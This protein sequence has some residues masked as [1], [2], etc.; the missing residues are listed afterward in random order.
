MSD[1][2]ISYSRHDSGF[3]HHLFGALSAESKDTWVDWED[4]PPT[5]EW[6]EEIKAAIE[7]A[8]SVIFVLSPDSVNS[9]ICKAEINHAA[10][11]NKRLVPIVCREVE[12]EQVPNSLARLNWIFFRESD[13][14]E[15]SFST[16]LEAL[17]TDLEWLHDHT[18]LLVK[19]LEWSSQNQEKSLLLRGSDLKAAEAWLAGSEQKEPAPTN[20]QTRY[21]LF[22]QKARRKRQ[23][24]IGGAL[25]FG[26]SVAL[27][28][29]S[30]AI[31]YSIVSE[32]N[33]KTAVSR[34]LSA[35]SLQIAQNPRPVFGFLDRAALLAVAA[36]KVAD[37][38]EARDALLRL[39]Q[40]DFEAKPFLR[41]RLGSF[42]DIIQDVAFSANGRWIA[43][44]H[45][46]GTVILWDRQKE[47]RKRVLARLGKRVHAVTFSPD[48][49]LIASASEQGQTGLIQVREVLTG[50]GLSEKPLFGHHGQP[51]LGLAFSGDS[52][53][54]AGAS[55]DNTIIVWDLARRELR[56]APLQGHDAVEDVVFSPTGKK[57]ASLGSG[58]VR[59]WDLEATKP[60]AIQL[61]TDESRVTGVAFSQD[62]ALIAT[63]NEGKDSDSKKRSVQLWDAMTGEA[64]EPEDLDDRRLSETAGKVTA[65]RPDG[66][67]F[68][69]IVV[70]GEVGWRW[71]RQ[72]QL[73]D[74][75]EGGVLANLD[76]PGREVKVDALSF[77]TVGEVLAI[78]AESLGHKGSV[79]LWDVRSR[80]PM[81]RP[82]SGHKRGASVTVF[83]LSFSPDGSRLV[84]GGL[85]ETI[86]T[87]D[88]L[89]AELVGKP[90]SLQRGRVLSVAISPDGKRMASGNADSS[91][92]LWNRGK[93]SEPPILLGK[94]EGWVNSVA[95]S[96][97]SKLLASGG[98]DKKVRL[99]DLA[100]VSAGDR[101]LGEHKSKVNAV[102]FSPEGERIASASE[103]GT[104]SIWEPVTGERVAELIAG[105]RG[106]VWDI[107]F[108]P[109]GKHLAIALENRA[110]KLGEVWLWDMESKRLS[111]EPLGRH[112]YS[113]RSVAFCSK[114]GRLA[115]AGG[116]DRVRL[117]DLGTGKSLGEPLE[118]TG[119]VSDVA[120]SPDCNWLAVAGQDK[121]IWLWDMDL[122]SR[123]CRIANREFTRD[124]WIRYLGEEEPYRE[125]CGYPDKD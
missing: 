78:A 109:N 6:L 3:V 30:I 121:A 98:D 115:S 92:L 71:V 16:L 123:A 105:E 119:I 34:Q 2:F 110:D 26:I 40:A 65:I 54:L 49:K 48:S 43:A 27:I 89:K 18:R 29:A 58:T 33:R 22:S 28:L 59:V 38:F 14:F 24:V 13:S 9:E 25:I 51:I 10:Q 106:V 31:Y 63:V 112:E 72:A 57:L 82:L 124:E 103:D 74:V 15:S 17:N 83:S 4:I 45:R 118:T 8:D 88:T 122:R 76:V 125:V 52:R 19:A 61:Q 23:Q 60:S 113:A 68:V 32:S 101:V 67:Q 62:G 39:L 117:W 84:S 41:D 44:A 7:G 1:V 108:S 114:D 37:T 91:V 56:Y 12:A 93:Q 69:S 75:A 99:W 94:H 100:S 80:L 86:R 47:Y 64:L 46:D 104:V 81:R 36:G 70:R 73:R 107:A 85:D 116:D 87:W 21:I 42:S 11:H 79:W 102:A 35:Q 96:P 66:K 97:D 95:F 50:K 53:L 55:S 20:T 120:F 111:G 77:D 90:L 5:A